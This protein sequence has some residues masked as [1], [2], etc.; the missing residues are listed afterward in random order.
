MFATPFAF[1]IDEQGVIASAGIVN[2][3]Q[4][5]GFLFSNAGEGATEEAHGEAEEEV[6]TA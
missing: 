1:L 6:A 5:V 2:N 4:H 3:R